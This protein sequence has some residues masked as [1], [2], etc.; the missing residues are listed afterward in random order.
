MKTNKNV[1]VWVYDP[2]PHKV[3]KD[4]AA[5][6]ESYAKILIAELKPKYVKD[7]KP[8]HDFNYIAD[9]YFKWHG[10]RFYLCSKYNCPPPRAI[11][12]S[13]ESKF[14]RLEYI[15]DGQFQ[16]F[17]MRYTGQWIKLEEGITLKEAFEVIRK[18]PYFTP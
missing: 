3:P 11:S 7:K 15:G 8:K 17:F 16:L 10:N 5:T 13:F 9:I 18:A 6:I 1:K 12:P 4:M 14:A 2:K